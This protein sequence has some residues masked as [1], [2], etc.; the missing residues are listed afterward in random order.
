MEDVPDVY[1][2]EYH[3]DAVLVCMDETSR[4]LTKETRIPVP[5]RPARYDYEYERSGTANL[6]M[7][8]APPL[9]QRH[10]RVTKRRTKQDFAGLPKTS[11][12]STFPKRGLSSRWII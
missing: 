11:P 9:G 10:G 2:R 8:H 12:M 5:G 6:F 4:Q 1:G 3:D 7:A